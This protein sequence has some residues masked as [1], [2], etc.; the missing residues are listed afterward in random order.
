MTASMKVNKHA[1]YECILLFNHFL[2]G[3]TRHSAQPVHPLARPL[4]GMFRGAWNQLLMSVVLRS[5]LTRG[6][7]G[8]LGSQL[9]ANS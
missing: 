7:G 3:V 8:M 1:L 9:L 5:T 2:V 6:G 4:N